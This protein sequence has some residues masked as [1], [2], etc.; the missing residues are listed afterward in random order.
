MA[1]AAQPVLLG[2]LPPRHRSRCQPLRGSRPG[3]TTAPAEPP[4]S[5]RGCVGV[6][7]PVSELEKAHGDVG[8][9]CATP[10]VANLAL[11]G[12]QGD[13]GPSGPP[14]PPGEDGDRGDDGEVGPRGLPGEPGPR[15]LLGPKGPPGPPGPPGLPGPQGAI[16]PPGEKGLPGPQGAIGPPGEKMAV[17]AAVGASEGLDGARLQFREWV[18]STVDP[19]VARARPCSGSAEAAAAVSR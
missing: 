5:T 8:Q 15:G 19:A 14:G 17:D 10:S 6:G 13:P 4:D 16:G 9:A 7:A 12:F 11:L 2:P 18:P 1:A 3:L